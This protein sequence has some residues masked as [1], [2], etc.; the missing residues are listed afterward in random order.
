MG[1]A[2]GGATHCHGKVVDAEVIQREKQLPR[3]DIEHIEDVRTVH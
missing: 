2:A 3:C 1:D